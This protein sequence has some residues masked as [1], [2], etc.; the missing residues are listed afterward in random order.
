M[1][2]VTTTLRF[3]SLESLLGRLADQVRIG[4]G[5]GL[6]IYAASLD[7]QPCIV[8]DEGTMVEWLGA[9][10]D[11]LGQLVNVEV[12]DDVDAR[13]VRIRELAIPRR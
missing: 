2:D 13:D 1:L 12:F 7:S 4:G 11:L 10:D 8:M 3:P 5:E 9:D 6:V